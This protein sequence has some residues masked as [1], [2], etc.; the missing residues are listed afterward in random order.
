MKTLD[1]LRATPASVVCEH[2]ASQRACDACECLA[3]EAEVERLTTELK[4]MTELDDLQLVCLNDVPTAAIQLTGAQLKLKA[5]EAAVRAVRA[6]VN[7]GDS[8]CPV[9]GAPLDKLYA[10]VSEAGT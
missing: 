4:E 10:L 5:L 7:A 1:E 2:G 8:P 3:L 6:S 9:A